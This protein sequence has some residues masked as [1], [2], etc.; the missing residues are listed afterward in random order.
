MPDVSQVAQ[1]TSGQ[2]RSFPCFEPLRTVEFCPLASDTDRAL[3]AA[4]GDTRVAI[5]QFQTSE[6]DPATQN[7]SALSSLSYESII[8]VRHDTAVSAIAWSPC[9][10]TDIPQA[11][12]SF[13]TAGSDH[14][15][16]CYQGDAHQQTVQSLNGHTSYVNACAYEPLEGTRVAT[17]SDDRSCCLW[18]VATGQ[19]I[20]RLPLSSYGMAVRW[21]PSDPLKLMVAER[22]GT[23]TI[24]DLVSCQPI[25]TLLT[26]GAGA[27]V[28]ADWSPVN[29]NLFGA[30]AG[31]HSYVWDASMGSEPQETRVVHNDG[32]VKFRWCRTAEQQFA[33]LGYPPHH[34]KVHLTGSQKVPI[35]QSFPVAGGLSW[36]PTFP[37]CAIGGDRQIHVCECIV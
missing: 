12:L 23:V 13:C 8:N 4:G 27:L 32:A 10:N 18:D 36:H 30:V 29:N 25:M 26:M 35:T 34:F 37:L 19:C 14:V 7:C 2:F 11:R 20:S 28:D 1:G 5:G 22:Q 3:I 9:T 16:R 33:T 31:N 24:Y 6:V 15:I 17:V 21:H